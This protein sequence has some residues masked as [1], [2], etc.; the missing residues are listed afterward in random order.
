VSSTSRSLAIIF[1]V[2]F[3]YTGL[4]KELIKLIVIVLGFT[5]R[6]SRSVLVKIDSLNF[7]TSYYDIVKTD[8]NYA[9]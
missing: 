6:I 4:I 7:R 1:L 8:W 2:V 9:H 5:F 3:L